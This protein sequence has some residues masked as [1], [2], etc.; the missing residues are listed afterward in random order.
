MHRRGFIRIGSI[1][2]FGTL[3]WGD[4]LR[5]RAAAPAKDISIIHLWLAGGLSHLD[6]FDMRP[7]ADRKYRSPFR[8]IPTTVDGLQISEHLPRTAQRMNRV[9]LIRSM[10]HKQSAHGA[11]QTLMLSGHDALPTLLAPAMASVIAKELGA[12]NELPP[13]VNIPQPRGNNARAGFLGPRYNPFSAGNVNVPNYSVRDMDLPLGVDWARMEG[14]HS[15]LHLVDAK[16]R[17]WDT[18]EAFGTLDSYYQSALE[19]MKSPRAKKAFN[20]AEEPEKV[21]NDYGR[22]QMGQGCLLARRLVEAGVRFVSV[23]KGDNEWDHHANLF[24]AYANEFMPELDNAFSALLDDLEQRGMLDST[25]V[26]VTGEFGRTA[27]INVN[28]GRDHWPN[29]FSL[30]VAGAGV[31]RGQVVGASD[32]DGMYVKDR[33]VE[34]PDFTA[35]IFKKL[36]IDFQKEY[37]SNIGR[38]L[39]ISAGKPLNFLG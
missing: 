37:V 21:R 13:Y 1:A 9:T 36:G 38:P 32:A 10:T 5:L 30:V 26:L 16:I 15:L 4:V 3:S 39:K 18:S 14:R 34:V 31:P 20:I 22:T 19:L 29:C 23:G 33:P 24:P 6:T 8:Q 35:T 11:A 25:L 12:R 17:N 27:E 7:Q 2:A 28:T